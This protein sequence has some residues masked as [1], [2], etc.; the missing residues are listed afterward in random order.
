MARADT[1]LKVLATEDTLISE[2]SSSFSSRWKYRVR[3]RVRP[4][5]SRV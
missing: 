4:A 1:V 5:R 2:S 3:S